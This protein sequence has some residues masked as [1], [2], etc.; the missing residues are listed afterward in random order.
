MRIDQQFITMLN[1]VKIS[2]SF[3]GS[4][5]TAGLIFLESDNESDSFGGAGNRKKDAVPRAT[6][7]VE[8]FSEFDSRCSESQFSPGNKGLLIYLFCEAN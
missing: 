7:E 2:L 5:G 4:A 8:I 6:S 1:S 3:S